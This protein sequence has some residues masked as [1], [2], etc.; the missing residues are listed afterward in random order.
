MSDTTEAKL[1]SPTNVEYIRDLLAQA[2]PDGVPEYLF[3]AS[4]C[5]KYKLHT[6]A[7]AYIADL[8]ADRAA[9]RQQ[10]ATELA[11]LLTLPSYGYLQGRTTDPQDDNWSSYDDESRQVAK[12][13]YQGLITAAAARLGIELPTKPDHDPA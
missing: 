10:V 11:G 9:F 12:G 6:A 2:Y 13:D 3:D 7:P 4:D 8:L 1:L 5:R